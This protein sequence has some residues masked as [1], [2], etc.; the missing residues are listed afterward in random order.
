MQFVG[1]W[2]IA[3]AALWPAA[4]WAEATQL[5]QVLVVSRHGIR[6]PY[7]LGTEIPSA[8]VLQRFVRNPDVELPLSAVAWGTNETDD[9]PDEVVSP[10]LTAHGYHVVELMGEVRLGHV[11]GF[12]TMDSS[13]LLQRGTVVLPHVSVSRLPGRNHVFKCLCLCGCQ[14]AGQC[15]PV[16]ELVVCTNAFSCGSLVG[17]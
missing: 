9:D 10:K 12:P 17:L 5:R 8:E 2:M 7:G 4:A 3:A 11:A 13:L 14:S 1:R 15:T 6:G 16:L